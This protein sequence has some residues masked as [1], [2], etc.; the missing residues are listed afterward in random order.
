MRLTL[1]FFVILV[2][3]WLTACE[4]PSDSFERVNTNDP[5]SP[6][7]AGGTVTGLSSVADSSGLIT[8]KWPSADNSVDKHIIEK[9]LGDSLSFSPIGELEPTETAFVDDSRDVRQDTYYKL[10]SYMEVDGIGDVLY[11]T[12][13]TK[14]EFGSISN[15]EYEFQEDSNQLKLTWSTDVPF[16]THFIISSENVI[17][18]QL[19]N[20]VKISANGNRHT[21]QDPLPDIDFENRTYTITG[22]I[23]KDGIAEAVAEKEITFDAVSFFRP[24]NFQINILNEQDWEISWESNA[25]FASEVVLERLN[26]FG[27][28][29]VKLPS[30]T[31]SYTDSRL[32]DDSSDTGVNRMRRYRLTFL[33]DNGKSE[34]VEVN[35]DILIDQPVIAISNIPQHDPNSLIVY[36]AGFGDDKHLIK[37]YIIEKPHPIKP[38]KFIEVGRADGVRNFQFLDTNV[39]GSESP[40]YRV[41]TLT[42]IPS[43][44]AT[45]TYSYDYNLDYEFDTDMYYVTSVEV[46]SDKKYLAAS[47]FRSGNGNS[48]VIN[49]I[50]ARTTIS[51]INIP[52]QQI[53]DMKIAP[54]DETIYF[55]VPSD[56]AIYSADFPSGENVEKV[57]DDAVVDNSGIF[58]IDVSADNLFIV[59]TGGQGFV[60][61]WSLN[62]FEPEFIF[63]EYSTPTFYLYKNI[64]ISPDGN[65]ILANNGRPIIL[66]AND[67][68]LIETL[69]W[70]D[71][72]VTDH[73]FS[74][75]G[76]YLSFVSGFS[77]PHIFSTENMERIDLFS[78]GRRVDFH[79]E[80]NMLVI[81]AR[82]SVYTFDIGTSS[83][84][85]VIS[86]DNGSWPYHRIENK[87]TY[88]DDDRVVT[89]SGTGSFQIWKKSSSQRRWKNVI[90]N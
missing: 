35:D 81:S 88:L 3:T 13:D 83:I 58:N 39:T 48:I 7:F 50:D 34:S 44:P 26:F 15:E 67:G 62:T 80:K 36:G 9:S 63:S 84:I 32:L 60:K 59:G 23:E 71:Q 11:G 28:V 78:R 14:L 17:S 37:E 33:T 31:R 12:T 69:P 46:S 41:R 61:K 25:F 30:E 20:T 77:S 79:P 24:Q 66:D 54:N 87:I 68:S 10:S 51:D 70:V 27:G 49:D 6:N 1:Q 4:T 86:G 38:D 74:S 19:E 52:G 75:D 42:S 56:R 64:A 16:F 57:I 82:H 45:F 47:S 53:S 8:L 29:V 72:N 5:A 85:D 89:I 43:R 22:I 65:Q 2:V 21:F 76:N 40:V 90:F 55:A 18:E 73:Q